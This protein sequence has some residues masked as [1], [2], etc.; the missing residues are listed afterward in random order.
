M[1]IEMME[2]AADCEDRCSG[3]GVLCCSIDCLESDSSWNITSVT[4][5]KKVWNGE[6]LKK[7]G[8]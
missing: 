8:F 2:E 6:N 7:N 1:L 5:E 4:I 3:V